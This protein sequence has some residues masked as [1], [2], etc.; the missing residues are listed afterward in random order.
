[1]TVRKAESSAM[2][3]GTDSEIFF[4]HLKRG[5][6]PIEGLLKLLY[7]ISLQAHLSVSQAL[8]SANVKGE[9]CYVLI[10]GLD[11]VGVPSLASF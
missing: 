11:V 3:S 9:H 2:S 10:M 7:S 1:L 6:I 5:T 4:N 8:M